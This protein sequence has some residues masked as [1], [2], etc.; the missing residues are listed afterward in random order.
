M[1]SFMIIIFYYG[2]SLTDN[3][4]FNHLLVYAQILPGIPNTLFIEKD[5]YQ[6]RFLPYPYNP[7]VND[8][9][10]FNLNIFI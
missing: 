7:K 2:Y 4:L 9:T 8:F 6:I 5:S 10:L 1:I 3:N